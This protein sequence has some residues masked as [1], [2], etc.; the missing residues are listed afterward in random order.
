MQVLIESAS[1]AAASV[2]DVAATRAQFVMRR[3]AAIVPRVRLR[4]S[5]V[6]G[7]RGGVDKQCRV[8]LF[9]PGYGTVV[10]TAFARDW[11]TALDTALA[12]AAHALGRLRQRARRPAR[13]SPRA[14]EASHRAIAPAD[15]A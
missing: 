12:R 6:N 3:M 15:P 8:D 13:L 2:R 9:A 11:R 7:P 1:R 5:D 14:L 10:V 4:L